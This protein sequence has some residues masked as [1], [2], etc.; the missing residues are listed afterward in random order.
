MNRRDF[1]RLTAT[2][3][4]TTALTEA[5]VCAQ[6]ATSS[7]P[8]GPPSV[9]KALMKAGTQHGHTDAILRACAGFGVNN[10]CSSLPSP[11]LDNAWT[12]DSLSRLKER[13]ESFGISLDMVPLPLSSYEISRSESPA[14]LLGGPDRDRQI[15][16]ICQMIR[17]AARAGIMQ[18][19]YNLTFIGIPRTTPARGRGPS[20]YSTFVYAEGT[21]DPPLTIAGSVN[22]DLYWERITY[23]LE[24]VVPVAEQYKVRIGCHPQ[25][26]G[27]PRGK[28][29]RGVETVLGS[30]DGLKRFVS[31]KESPY[32]GLNFC[33]GTV[34]E[35]LEKP[36][37]EI[38]DVIRYFGTRK[39]IFSVHFRNI[40]GGFLNFR[41]TFIDDGDVNMLEAMRVYKEVGYDG[42]MMPDHVPH[43]EGDTG[44]VQGF[45]FAFGYIKALIAAVNAEG[46]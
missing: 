6:I 4:G 29:W 10:I 27:M 17:N 23:F 34:S 8:A 7:R 26:P 28:G 25:D 15:D 40:A 43:V 24:R 9:G 1:V 18:A 14:V 12:V 2:A 35:M 33:Q 38:F 11:K 32:H 31:I 37:E 3:A 20:T 21:Q 19:K 16:D 44:Q 22:A 42:M 46:C 41:E 36:G 13:V 5:T 39:K 45:A 30:V